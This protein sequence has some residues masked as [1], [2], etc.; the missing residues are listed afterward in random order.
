MLRKY[1][2]VS[3]EVPHSAILVSKARELAVYL[4]DDTKLRCFNPD[5]ATYLK[6]TN[7]CLQISKKKNLWLTLCLQV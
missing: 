2:R 1:P 7:I 5:L 6:E 4:D 3:G